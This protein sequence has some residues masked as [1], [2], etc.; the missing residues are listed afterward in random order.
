MKARSLPPSTPLRSTTLPW[1][2]RE[3]LPP[4]NKE[5]RRRAKDYQPSAPAE[6]ETFVLVDVLAEDAKLSKGKARLAIQH[7]QVSVNEVIV[8]DP[9][10]R[11]VGIDVVR[12][13]PPSKIHVAP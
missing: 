11:I 9:D 1:N 6:P 13:F 8:R 2:A 12:F 3:V 5:K 4:E 10:T 7:G